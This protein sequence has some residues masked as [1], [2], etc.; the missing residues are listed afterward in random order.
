VINLVSY[1]EIGGKIIETGLNIEEALLQNY[2]VPGDILSPIPEK[3]DIFIGAGATAVAKAAGKE[4]YEIA[5]A[6]RAPKR[7]SRARYAIGLAGTLAAADGP[8]PIGDVIA[9]GVL[10]GF[11][12]YQGYHGVKDLV[13]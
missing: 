6:M 5:R 2:M 12:V 7:F 13:Q 11:A 8:L 4:K 3:K 10:T 9:M 1:F